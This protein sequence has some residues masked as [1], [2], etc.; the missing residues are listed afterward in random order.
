[1]V[2]WQVKSYCP[3]DHYLSRTKCCPIKMLLWA[4][5][6]TSLYESVPVSLRYIHWNG[7][8]D[9]RV[10]PCLLS[11]STT[12]VFPKWLNMRIL[13]TMAS[14]FSPWLSHFWCLAKI[15]VFINLIF[16]SLITKINE[17]LFIY[18]LAIWFPLPELPSCCPCLI[19]Y[20]V[21]FLFLVNLQTF[22]L[23]SR[24]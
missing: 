17:H 18:F 6:N 11:L 5:S 16:N 13:S 24:Y 21:F 8:W 14:T 15:K 9:P 1:M 3:R 20:W 2:I 22:L 4:S 19:F 23:S 7:F 10:H 12:R